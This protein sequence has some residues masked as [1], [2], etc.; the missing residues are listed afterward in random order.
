MIYEAR[1]LGVAPWSESE[2][3]DA[4][5]PIIFVLQLII[6]QNGGLEKNKEEIKIELTSNSLKDLLKEICRAFGCKE[7]YNKA[8]LYTKKGVEIQK[9]DVEFLNDKDILYVAVN[10]ENFNNC[11]I[12]DD[13]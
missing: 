11:A 2:A 12:L 6:R 5:D 4:V 1:E 9:T 8:R 7:R 3:C 10:G 13:F